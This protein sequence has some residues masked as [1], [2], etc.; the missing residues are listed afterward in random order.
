[1]KRI[2]VLFFLF[3]FISIFSQKIISGT[4]KNTE[5]ENVASAS[6]TVEE[7]GSDAIIAYGI[8]NSKGEYKVFLLLLYPML[9]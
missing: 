5:G 9:I 6:V 2:T 4:I 8:S 7:P 3:F 1:M